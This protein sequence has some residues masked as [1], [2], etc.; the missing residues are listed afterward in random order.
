M[1]QKAKGGRRE[2]QRDRQTDRQAVD[3][4]EWRECK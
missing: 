3:I 2:M 4:R 1:G